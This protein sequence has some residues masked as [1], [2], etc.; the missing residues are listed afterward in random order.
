MEGKRLLIVTNVDWF[1]ISHRLVIAKAAKEAGWKVY[2][3]CEDT[4]RAAEIASEGI[5]F[6]PFRFSRSGTNPLEEYKT[7]C[8][9]KKLYKKVRP[10]VVHQITIKPVVYGGLAAKNIHV[11]GVVNAISGMGY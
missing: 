3:A 8:A 4:G 1:L 5:E 7:Y 11:S 2:V 6:I 9:F 10:D